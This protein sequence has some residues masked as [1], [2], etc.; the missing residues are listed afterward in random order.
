MVNVGS[1][2]KSHRRCGSGFVKLAKLDERGRKIE[3]R[4]R[5][6]SVELDAAPQPSDCLPILTEKNFG[7][8]KRTS[9]RRSSLLTSRGYSSSI[10]VLTW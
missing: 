6:I 7:G 2:A 3:M 4:K 1:S 10:G 9:K 5:I 8:A